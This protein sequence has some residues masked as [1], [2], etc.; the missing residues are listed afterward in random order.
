[1]HDPLWIRTLLA[2]H[3]AA[4]SNRFFGFPYS[5]FHG[6]GRQSS[7]ALGED[8]LLGYGERCWFGFGAG[9]PPA[10]SVSGSGGCVQLLQ[11]IH[12]ISR[13]EDETHR[14]GSRSG[15]AARLGCGRRHF[16]REPRTRRPGALASG[17]DS[18]HD[19]SGRGVRPDWYE[20]IRRNTVELHPPAARQDV[21]VVWTSTGN[22]RQLHCRLDGFF[23]GDLRWL[24]WRRLVRVGNSY[25]Y[26]SPRYSAHDRILP[27]EI[28]RK[29]ARARVTGSIAGRTPT[30]VSRSY[31]PF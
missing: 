27:E 22:D 1:M 26:R 24:L 23:G 30:C 31:V 21:L 28:R 2:L 15:F 11:R 7:P 29:E 13:P 8:L 9:L 4:G 14:D 17:M 18:A 16:S 20:H 10:G 3:I 12:R 19:D 5:T 25:C 6:E